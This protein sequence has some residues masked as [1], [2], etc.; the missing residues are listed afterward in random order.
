M[1][2]ANR[3]DYLR[4]HVRICVDCCHF[5]VMRRSVAALER[6]RASREVGRVQLSSAIKVVF[7][8]MK[9]RVLASSNACAAADD[10][11][12]SGHRTPRH[13]AHALS[14]LTSR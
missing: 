10:L 2:P 6:V 9:Q 4:D 7:R 1:R 12:P 3:L 13:V 11:S 8:A 14:D 5:A